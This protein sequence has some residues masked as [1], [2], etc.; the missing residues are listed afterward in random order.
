MKD[1]K[2]CFQGGDQ[3]MKIFELIQKG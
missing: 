2:L 1:A 3:S